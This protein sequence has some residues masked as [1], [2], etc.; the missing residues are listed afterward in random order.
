MMTPAV[1]ALIV[2]SRMCG[3]LSST[4][5]FQVVEFSVLRFEDSS[6]RGVD[7]R[8][9][10]GRG[11][12]VLRTSTPDLGVFCNAKG[13]FTTGVDT[14]SKSS[15]LFNDDDDTESDMSELCVFF[16]D[17]AGVKGGRLLPLL[18]LS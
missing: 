2:S 4:E 10:L 9:S 5:R 1:L 7:L 13:D 11:D 18:L 14:P 15:R 17:T 12:D 3:A 8:V 16:L 6:P